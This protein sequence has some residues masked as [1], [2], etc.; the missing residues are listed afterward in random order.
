MS[1]WWTYH[2]RDFLLFTPR[3]YYRLFELADRLAQSS[4]SA[5]QK[6][7]KRELARMTYGD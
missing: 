6:R 7:L 1:E 2:L 3:T 4:D 5:E